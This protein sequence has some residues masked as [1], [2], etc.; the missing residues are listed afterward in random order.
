MDCWA[1][2]LH[3]CAAANSS[4]HCS[5]QHAQLLSSL[6]QSPPPPALPRLQHEQAREQGNDAFALG[7]Y[8]AA[9]AHYSRALQ[10]RPSDAALWSN[11]AAAYLAKGW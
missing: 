11:R 4:I 5:L 3:L 8:D 7:D 1:C 6:A 9:V 10:L 2:M